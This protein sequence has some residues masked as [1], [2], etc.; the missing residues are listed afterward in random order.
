[1]AIIEVVKYDGTPDTFAWKH[2]NTELGTWTQLIVNDAQEAILFKDGHACD[3]FG[4]GRYT[5]DTANIPILNHIVNLPFG[6][7]SPF[8]A[9]VWFINKAVSL[10]VKW[11]TVTP[12]QLQ[13]PKYNLFLPVRAYGQFGIQV[14]DSVKFLNQLVGTMNA[15]DRTALI[16]YFRGLYL[17]KVK[18]AVSTY[19][20]H[21]KIS[22]V[23]I[24]AY[25]NEL[26]S[27]LAEELRPT[28]EMYGLQLVSFFV[29]DVNVPEDDPTVIKLKEALVKKAEMNIIGFDYGQQRSFDTMEN[30]A[31]NTGAAN[32]GMNAGMGLGMGF[33]MGNLFHEQT[34]HMARSLDTQARQAACIQCKKPISAGAKFCSVCGAAQEQQAPAG[35]IC[36]QCG[37]GLQSNAKFCYECGTPLRRTCKSCGAEIPGTAKFCLECGTS[38]TA[39]SDKGESE[40]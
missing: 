36:P 5:L 9:E 4:A 33:G 34:V 24:N 38:V 3:I 20:I 6:G 11:G 1:M 8:A 27:F 25:L 12:I 31:R 35:P 14:Q 7:R 2:P 28:M 26:S 13:D 32:A 29:N 16:N 37:T 18:D 23:E 19:I 40:S 10:A 15:F 39:K 30:A 21:E 17:T 22:I